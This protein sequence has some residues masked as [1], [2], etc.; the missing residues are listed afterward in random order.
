MGSVS[1]RCG[2]EGSDRWCETAQFHRHDPHR[3]RW[4]GSRPARPLPCPPGLDGGC[5]QAE[6]WLA[7][8][9]RRVLRLFE[10]GLAPRTRD[11]PA[12]AAS[13]RQRARVC[14]SRMCDWHAP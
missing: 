6:P 11:A 10:T 2:K 4:L 13:S 14:E 7:A 8:C 1:G 3:D 5:C 9:S 12:R